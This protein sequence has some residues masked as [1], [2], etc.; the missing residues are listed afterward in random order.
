MAKGGELT[1]S[2]PTGSFS[3]AFDALLQE[4]QR[5]TQRSEVLAESFR[6]FAENSADL[7]ALA[8]AI[9]RKIA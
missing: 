3:P 2:E 7:D 5:S 8:S 1:M 6:L 9:A 4:H